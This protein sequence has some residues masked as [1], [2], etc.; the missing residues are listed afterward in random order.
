VSLEIIFVL[1]LGLSIGSFL[2]VLIYRI[3]KGESIVYPSSHCPKCRVKLRVWHNV[4]I[5]SYLF[6]RGKCAF[7]NSKISIQYP[8][9]E[10]A[11]G[12]LFVLFYLKLGFTVEALLF[13]G[14]FATLLA[15]S[16]ID[17]YHKAVPDSLNL[18]ALTLAIIYPLEANTILQNLENALLFGGAF[19][20]LRFYVS[21]FTGRE[22]MG[23]GDI[24]VAG[25]I[26]AVLGVYTGTFAIFFS[27]ILAL[28]VILLSKEREMPFIPFLA[29]S[30]LI[31]YLFEKYVILLL[32]SL[33]F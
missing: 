31:T 25:T 21:Y 14:I 26:G 11:T 9:V 19:A 4:P 23:E 1:V 6:L 2:N 32:N 33:L 16:V 30:L 3:P 8:V 15:L 29:L 20:F 24:M 22:A 5:L 12:V 18:T 10:G 27:S 13:S 28:P 17:L 7:C